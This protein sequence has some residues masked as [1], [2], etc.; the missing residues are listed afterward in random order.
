M[1][2]LSSSPVCGSFPSTRFPSPNPSPTRTEVDLPIEVDQSFNSSMSLAEHSPVGMSPNALFSGSAMPVSPLPVKQ[3][4][5]PLFG[6]AAS[7]PLLGPPRR[8]DPV[9]LQSRSSL[10]SVPETSSPRRLAPINTGR[11]FGREL[12]INA[13]LSAMPI[14]GSSKG[15][16]LP[17][18]FHKPVGGVGMQWTLF[19]EETGHSAFHPTLLRHHV[20]RPS[21][22]LIV[23]D[24]QQTEPDCLSPTGIDDLAMDI[25]SP[26]PPSRRQS[27]LSQASPAFSGSKSFSGSPGLDE[28]FCQSPGPSLMPP[29]KRRSLLTGSPASSSG[30]PSAKRASLGLSRNMEKATSSSGMLFGA[31]P[32]AMG[33]RRP[34][35]YKRPVPTAL[36]PT[37]E[38]AKPLCGANSA[39][40]ILSAVKAA[41]GSQPGA[42]PRA[43][44]GMMRRAMSVCDQPHLEEEEESEF[45]GSPS[46]VAAQAEYARRHGHTLVPRIDGSPAFKPMR[47]TI[48]GTPCEGVISPGN[49][50]RASP[51]GQPGLPG[52]GQDELEG[53]ILPCH[54]VK[55]DGLVRINADTLD[56]LLAGQYDGKMRKCHIL[57]C[58]FDYEYQGGHIEGAIN[59]KSKEALEDL[60]FQPGTGLNA[61]ASYPFPQPSRSG[62]LGDGE[63]VVLILHCEFSAKRAPTFAKHLRSHDRGLNS[64]HYPRVFYPEVYVLEGG[65]HGFYQ[66]RPERCEPQGYVPMDDPRHFTRR[67]SDLHEFR[68]NTTWGRTKSFAYGENRNKSV[69]A[70]ELQGGLLSAMMGRAAGPGPALVF[71]AAN[72]AVGRRG[73]AVIAE[74]E[75]E[76]DS[77]SRND[78]GETDADETDSPCPRALSGVAR[79]LPSQPIFGTAKPRLLARAPMA[80]VQS[81]A[82]PQPLRF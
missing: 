51:F 78:G 19:N 9:P 74:A 41:L 26:A 47:S 13:P 1:D 48:V 45:E 66:S 62:E 27:L 43:A 60:L 23:S 56:A 35:P 44:P 11:A 2:M 80:R 4:A 50:K 70:G 16:M 36:G 59:V 32:G 34:Q 49:K 24:A 82:G 15:K 38:H 71:A 72:V 31:R 33:M 79:P 65:Y 22:L 54:N 39:F 7:A 75:D 40:P 46:V 63:Q 12:S 53:K 5:R 73:G 20:S 68:K 42:F 30:S 18:A 28:F 21:V 6:P 25:D 10:G 77:P 8:P 14:L 52:F 58:R 55:D 76:N 81:Y 29:A 67:D 17:P 69:A 64:M 57:D 37:L 61:D 3:G